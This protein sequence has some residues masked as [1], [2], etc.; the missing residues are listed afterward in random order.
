MITAQALQ[1]L[2]AAPMMKGESLNVVM[3]YAL[4]I[5]WPVRG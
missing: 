5:S 1:L 4:I 3:V 2:A